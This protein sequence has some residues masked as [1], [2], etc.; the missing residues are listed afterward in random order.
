[1]IFVLVIRINRTVRRTVKADV[2]KFRGTK[3]QASVHRG[4]KFVWVVSWNFL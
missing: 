2:A 1:M 4:T 3:F